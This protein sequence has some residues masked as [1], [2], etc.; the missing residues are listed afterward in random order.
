MDPTVLFGTLCIELAFVW[1]DL[2]HY[3]Y[4]LECKNHV[5]QDDVL[6]CAIYKEI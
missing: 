4:T 5:C 3:F 2:C 1:S 6:I